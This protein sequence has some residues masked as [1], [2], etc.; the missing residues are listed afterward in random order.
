MNVVA[1]NRQAAQTVSTAHAQGVGAVQAGSKGNIAK[2]ESMAAAVLAVATK[3][4]GMSFGN[5]RVERSRAVVHNSP[6][7]MR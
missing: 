5:P 1:M 3:M 2:P 7:K 4:E 6:S